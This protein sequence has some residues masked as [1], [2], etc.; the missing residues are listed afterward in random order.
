MKKLFL[1]LVALATYFSSYSQ[2]VIKNSFMYISSNTYVVLTKNDPLGIVDI[3]TSGGIYCESESS[4][5]K[6]LVTGSTTGDYVVPFVASDGTRIP[7]RLNVTSSTS[8]TEILFNSYETANNNTPFPLAVN[9]MTNNAHLN[10]SL[11]VLDRFWQMK[12]VG[13][14]ASQP[15][16]DVTFTY[17]DIDLVGNSVSE[18]MLVM[19]RYNDINDTWGDW[20]Y[21]P[22]AVPSMNQITISLSNPLDY[23]ENWTIV[24]AG[25][26]LPI[27]F[28]NM[29]E[30][31]NSGKSTI[32]WSVASE[33]NVDFYTIEK[34]MN[35]HTT[36]VNNVQAVGNSSS[37]LNY[38]ITDDEINT[39][40]AYYTLKSTDQDGSANTAQTIS[41]SCIDN[42]IR[43]VFNNNSLV[44]TKNVKQISLYDVA[45]KLI[46][47]VTNTDH[48]NFPT[49]NQVYIVSIEFNDYTQI[50]IKLVK[51]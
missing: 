47:R 6:W 37:Q 34:T 28:L 48:V 8:G 26:P 44:F 18:S 43:W 24:D 5:I 50:N 19:Q 33:T 51:I 4:K 10:N 23:Y 14:P 1:F 45:G 42:G 2:L 16:V 29:Y 39:D 12:F 25:N 21:S 41:S 31:C 32:F 9:F 22:Y 30:I 36:V 49:V 40:Q 20:L 3:G 35:G 15:K 11:S 27:Q 7:L 38:Q 13:Y 46:D 17:A